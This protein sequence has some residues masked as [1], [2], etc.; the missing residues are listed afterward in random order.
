MDVLNRAILWA[1]GVC[2]VGMVVVI[3]WQV[4]LRFV[5]NRTP[6]WSEETALVLTLYFGF[7]GAAAAYRENMHIGVLFFRGRLPARYRGI[8]AAGVDACVGLFAVFM[9]VQGFVLAAAMMNQRLPALEIKVGYSY[10]PVAVSGLFVACFS[11][12]KLAAHFARGGAE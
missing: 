1:A 2:L 10:L 8:A 11:V 12:E 3:T 7:F 6:F 9:A 5:F 4:F